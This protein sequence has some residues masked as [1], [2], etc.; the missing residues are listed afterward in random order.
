[1]AACA[2]RRHLHTRVLHSRLSRSIIMQHSLRRL[3]AAVGVAAA[4][5][6]WPQRT[7]PSTHVRPRANCFG[8]DFECAPWR[9]RTLCVRARCCFCVHPTFH[10]MTSSCLSCSIAAG[11]ALPA[12]AVGGR[13]GDAPSP[14]GPTPSNLHESQRYAR[15]L[16]AGLALVSTP[17]MRRCHCMQAVSMLAARQHV[18][19]LSG[20]IFR[21]FFTP[22]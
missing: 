20:F 17:H 8:L 22:C 16:I 10:S 11:A 9:A 13:R 5:N 7:L 21:N 6:T 15:R 2:W 4:L 3:Q 14:A 18:A 19:L 12:P 1:M